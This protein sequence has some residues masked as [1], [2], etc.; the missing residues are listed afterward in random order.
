MRPDWPGLQDL[1]RH[2]TADI[3]ASYPVVEGLDVGDYQWLLCPALNLRC[4][5]VWSSRNLLTY[6]CVLHS[7][8]LRQHFTP[9]LIPFLAEAKALKLCMNL[10]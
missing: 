9:L 6:G 2:G 7:W 10:A 5:G 8:H 3:S 1:V 4:T